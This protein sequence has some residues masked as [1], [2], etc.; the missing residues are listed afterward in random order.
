MSLCWCSKK[1]TIWHWYH[2]IYLFALLTASSLFYQSKYIRLS[3][4]GTSAL[5]RE[6]QICAV[7]IHHWMKKCITWYMNHSIYSSLTGSIGRK[8][9][10]MFFSPYNK[11]FTLSRVLTLV[12]ACDWIV[13]ILM[14][15]Y[16]LLKV[17]SLFL[18]KQIYMVINLSYDRTSAFG[19]E[20]KPCTVEIHH[21]MKKS[22][23]WYMR[24][25]TY[26]VL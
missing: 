22:I 14:F 20:C 21:W 4:D 13:V 11:K 19:R 24:H 7:E 12:N 18:P 1:L 6:C 2:W 26:I 25:S 5:G 16:V 10:W 8:H 3:Y 17:S 23:T 15:E 9:H